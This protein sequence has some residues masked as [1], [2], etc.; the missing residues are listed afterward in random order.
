MIFPFEM[1]DSKSIN[2]HQI[3]SNN[4]VTQYI[5][6]HFYFSHCKTRQVFDAVF[7]SLFKVQ[8]HKKKKE[9]KNYVIE[10]MDVFSTNIYKKNE[11]NI[12]IPH[13]KKK[14]SLMSIIIVEGEG[15][16]KGILL[17]YHC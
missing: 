16:N 4:S 1:L 15:L 2:N 9:G 5:L 7:L 3:V 11:T 14:I 17:D 12:K 8:L 10:N 13:F 6:F